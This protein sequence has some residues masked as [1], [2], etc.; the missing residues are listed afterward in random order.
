MT[1]PVQSISSLERPL[2]LIFKWFNLKL[3]Q[4]LYD[5]TQGFGQVAADHQRQQHA[6]SHKYQY[7]TGLVDLN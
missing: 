3:L 7:F 2:N 6:R 4:H 5:L 1:S